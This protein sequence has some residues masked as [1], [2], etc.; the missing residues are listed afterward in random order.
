MPQM[1]VGFW[2]DLTASLRAELKAPVL[3]FFSSSPSGP[4][5]GLLQ[6][7]TLLLRCNST[8][9]ADQINKPEILQLVTRKA[10]AMLGRNVTVKTV[11][12]SVTPQNSEK[13]DRLL[14]FGR[15]HSD[16][17]KIKGE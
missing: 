2:T 13:M 5:Q 4:V 16:V 10:S 12:L 11:D 9:V 15:S 3:G 14:Q 7:D 17:I 8:F 6:A 1:P